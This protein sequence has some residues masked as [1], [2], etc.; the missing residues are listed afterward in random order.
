MSG[1]VP[2]ILYMGA[3][4]EVHP[5]IAGIMQNYNKNLSELRKSNV[6]KLVGV[7]IYQLPSVNDFGC[8]NGQLRRCNMF[9]LKQCGNKLCKMAH[10]LPTEMDK[11]Y[12]EQMVKMLSTS[13]VAV[14]TKTEIEKRG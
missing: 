6:Y 5:T 7:N 4:P 10:W 8:G 14:V 1:T 9:K 12:L 13:L 3:N 11:A 2:R